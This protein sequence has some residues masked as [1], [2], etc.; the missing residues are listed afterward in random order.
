ME[1]CTFYSPFTFARPWAEYRGR[2][3]FPRR[4]WASSSLPLYFPGAPF[5]ASA[6]SIKALQLHQLQ[7]LF[8][9][10]GPLSRHWPALQQCGAGAFLESTMRSKFIRRRGGRAQAQYEP[11]TYADWREEQRLI[12]EQEAQRQ[13]QR[14]A[15][16][17]NPPPGGFVVSGE[18]KC[19]E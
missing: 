4:A 8:C 3:Q 14:A 9:F 1:P 19:N 17:P 15:T 7:G 16:N 11:Q 10:V 2:N 13:A 18:P 5:K 6:L 12:A